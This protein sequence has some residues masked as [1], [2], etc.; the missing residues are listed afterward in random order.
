LRSQAHEDGMQRSVRWHCWP[1]GQLPVVQPA[2]LGPGQPFGCEPWGRQTPPPQSCVQ[3]QVP[4]W[5]SHSQREDAQTESSPLV[6]VCPA[7]HPLSSLHPS[8]LGSVQ[9]TIEGT[10]PPVPG[11]GFVIV[12]SPSQAPRHSEVPPVWPVAPFPPSGD[13][14]W[15]AESSRPPHAASTTMRAPTSRARSCTRPLIFI[16]RGYQIH[17]CVQWFAMKNRVL[18]VHALSVART[19]AGRRRSRAAQPSELTP[20]RCAR[21]RRAACTFRPLRAAA[22]AFRRSPTPSGS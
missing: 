15:E 22:S 8:G 20:P 18:R 14:A 16:A 21:A 2:G 1:T 12:A 10:A 3:R 6:Q 13:E 11:L 9:G 5:V 4:L 19:L 7:A 17:A